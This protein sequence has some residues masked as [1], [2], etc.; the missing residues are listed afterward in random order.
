MMTLTQAERL[1]R[2]ISEVASQ[3]ASDT[4][5]AKLA[6]D[7][8]ELCRAANRRLEQCAI[9]I[10]AGQFLQALQLAETPPPLLD[11]ITLL[12]FR[13]AAEWRAYCQAHQLPWAE[14]FYDKYIRLLN[15]TYGKGIAS[16]HPFYRDYRRAVMENEDARALSIL[17]VISRLNPSDANT[18]EELKRLEEKLLR[19]KLENMRQVMASGDAANI[20]ACLEQI[21]A[22]GLPVPAAHPVWQQ[23]QVA[24][25]QQMLRRAEELRRQDA[26]QDAEAVVEEI[27]ASA[28]RYNVRLPDA[29]ADIW[30]ALE[31]WTTQQRAAYAAEQDFRRALSALEY[32]V[33][34][35][36]SQRATN[37]SL[38]K[39]V[40]TAGFN[41]LAEKRREAERFG[42]TLAED[43][44]GRCQECSDWLR[45]QI[46]VANRRQRLVTIVTVLVV[47][48]AIGAA[49]PYLLSKARQEEF[50]QRVAR[51]ESNRKVSEAES[52]LAA[53]PDSW[54]TN[55]KMADAIG[56]A[57]DFLATEKESK[58]SFDRQLTGLQQIAAAGFRGAVA[59]VGA[60]RAE[61][62]RALTQL[63]PEYQSPAKTALGAWDAQWQ[64]FRNAELGAVLNRAEEAAQSLRATNGAEPV[65]ASLTRIQTMLS[66]STPLETQPPPL[67]Q[68]L[69]DRLARLTGKIENWTATTGK[70]EQAEAALGNASSLEQY[71]EALRELPLSPFATPAQKNAVTGID[72]LHVNQ[73]TLLGQL[74]LPNNPEAW[75]T[76]TNVTGWSASL[77]PEQPTGAE[78]DL[79]FKLRDDKNVRDVNAYDLITNAR[80]GN[81]LHTHTVFVQGAMAPDKAGQE[82]GMVDDPT[83]F[84]DT[85][86]FV[87]TSYSDW[88]YIKVK[89][90]YRTLE[91][92][93]YEH[94][95]LGELIDANTGNYQKPILQLFDQLNKESKASSIF[96]AFV[97][98]KLLAVAEARPEEWGLQWCP[99]AAAHL[100][101]LTNLGAGEIQSGDW[102]VPERSDKL[103]RPLQEYFARASAVPLELQARFLQQLAREACAKGFSFAG[104]IDSSGHPVL[105]AL[106]TP[107]TELCGW[108]SSG[109][110]TVLLRKTPAGDTYTPLA[111]PLPFTPLFAFAGDRRE[112][113]LQTLNA[114]GYSGALAGPILPPFFV[115]TL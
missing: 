70:W 107:A 23:A 2:R 33:N 57:R 73:E 71:L 15:S 86:H 94:L 22:S 105:R 53:I 61:C 16:D 41:A 49:L 96:R 21:E 4:Q 90:L 89:R 45:Q 106:A 5:T 114:T 14:P 74:L 62:E 93:S 68:G 97:T 29:D 31:E 108:S 20:Q 77:M 36:A 84:R 38:S 85:L 19:V 69:A 82:A 46:Q 24:R 78:K 34:T 32:E 50:A 51:L 18:K 60:G 101:A 72:S 95:G 80:P 10:E 17:R 65:R 54:K 113:L 92:D 87:H 88:D 30:T 37:A 3:P 100:Q 91:C 111:E 64:S 56:K 27:H 9:M 48:G 75:K 99:S 83:L 1:V 11:L 28:T 103:E 6:H 66:D 52:A 26:W 44:N 81:T 115:G 67:D 63:A 112:L 98:F 76:L 79:Y 59:Q 7:Y 42:Q 39:P 109:V 110:A 40:A 43:L 104:F 58:Q 12:A 102:L 35:I 13:Q 8:V 55:P 47:L 25:C